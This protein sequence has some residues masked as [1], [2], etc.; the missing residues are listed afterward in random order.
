MNDLPHLW[1]PILVTAVLVFIASALI[2]MVIRWHN[3]DYK[4]LGN[5]DAVRAAIRDGA[6]GPG[7]YSL[8]HCQDMK[9]MQQETMQQKFVQGPIGLLTLRKNGPPT[10]GAALLQWFVFT[11]V[12]ATIAGGLALQAFGLAADHHRAGHLVGMISLL[13][14]FGGSVQMAIWMGKPWGIVFKDLLDCLI[15]GTI[16]ALVFMWLWP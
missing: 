1:M 7:Q 11:V 12:V 15:Y 3:S 8:P 2:H 5:E 13:T 9:D 4:K 14:Y 16:S 6:A 10:M